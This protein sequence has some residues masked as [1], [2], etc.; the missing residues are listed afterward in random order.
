MNMMKRNS[1]LMIRPKLAVCLFALFLVAG[2]ASG[3]EYENT[4]KGAATGAA[5]GAGMGLLVGALTGDSEMAATAT[6]MGAAA[7]AANLGYE[8]FLQDQE[9][10]RTREIADAIRQSGQSQPS[11]DPDARAREELTRFLG[12]WSVTGWVLDEGE[13]RNVTSQVNGNVQMGYFVEMAWINLNIQGIDQQIWG[14]S[15]LGFDGRT[16]YSISS[17]FNTTPDSIDAD[18]GRWDGAQR[19]FI[20]ESGGANTTVR[21]SSPDRFTVTTTLSGSTI[22]SYTFTRT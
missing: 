10:N 13:R 9:N 11:A 15:T 2:C 5:I 18:N 8:G 1:A 20:F 4:R 16:G 3:P 17:R 12:A 14:T 19:A 21:F 7:G 22:E 6:V